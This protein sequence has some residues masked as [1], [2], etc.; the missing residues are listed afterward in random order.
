MK[1]LEQEIHEIK[2]LEDEDL[3]CSICNYYFSKNLKPYL[4]NCNHNLCLRCIDGIIE[5]NMFNC[6]I[7]R[8]VFT[9]EDKNNFQ[10]N[11][12]FLNLVN[13]I[14]DH[15]LIYCNKCQ[16]IFTFNEHFENCDQIN[17]KESNESLQDLNNLA[18]DCLK[19]FNHSNKHLNI[20]NNSEKS[21]YEEMNRI[22]KIININFYEIFS[23]TIQQFYEGIPKINYEEFIEEIFSFLKE[24]EGFVR[25]SLNIEYDEKSQNDYDYIYNNVIEIE[26]I[27]KFHFNKL[28]K[29]K[30]K[31][32]TK[33][34]YNE[35]IE[36]NRET[37]KFYDEIFKYNFTNYKNFKEIKNSKN[38]NLNTN[39]NVI[40]SENDSDYNFKRYDKSLNLNNNSELKQINSNLNKN[41]IFNEIDFLFSKD[42]KLIKENNTKKINLNEKVKILC[43]V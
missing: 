35:K 22:I 37:Q 9:L 40:E 15:K 27:I 42:K 43:F 13:K 16:K 41:D 38:N 31:E 29:L 12:K 24:Y 32:K 8:R 20:L 10:I 4:L 6:P 26:S 34:F 21:I 2:N 28:P 25:A 39:P 14:L 23:K 19:I 11:E 3:K 7:C 18:K 30:T 33:N 17:F 1:K 36:E 5:K